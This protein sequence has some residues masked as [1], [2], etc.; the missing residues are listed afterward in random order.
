MRFSYSQAAHV[1]EPYANISIRIKSNKCH[2]LLNILVAIITYFISKVLKK[3]L[4]SFRM[5]TIASRF[6]R[7]SETEPEIL[8]QTTFA[9]FKKNWRL[10]MKMKLFKKL[11]LNNLVKRWR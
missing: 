9:T 5:H 3:T 7:V 11:K 2:E 1:S 8:I 4:L 6:S 10:S